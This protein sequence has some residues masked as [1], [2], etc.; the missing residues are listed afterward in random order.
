MTTITVPFIPLIV[1]IVAYFAADAVPSYIGD[2]S[3]G[4]LFI[5]IAMA[6]IC[7]FVIYGLYAAFGCL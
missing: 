4:W 7:F 2:V 3:W 5:K 1:S 6:V